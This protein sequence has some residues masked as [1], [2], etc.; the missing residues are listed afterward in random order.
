MRRTIQSA[1]LTKYVHSSMLDSEKTAIKVLLYAPM[2]HL[3]K[4]VY[5]IQ[6]M[7]ILLSS[8]LFTSSIEN[9]GLD[10]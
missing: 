8:A 9:Q 7:F 10:R 2:L 5:R 3:Y 6:H 4:L 1:A